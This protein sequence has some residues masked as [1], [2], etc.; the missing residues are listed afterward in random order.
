MSVACH[1]AEDE[2]AYFSQI[3]QINYDLVH[4][5]IGNMLQHL[6]VL[7]LWVNPPC[8]TIVVARI[9]HEIIFL[10]CIIAEIEVLQRICG[11]DCG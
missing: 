8:L 10:L 3:I 11:F 5:P 6:H 1:L 9:I 7:K 4:G 2:S